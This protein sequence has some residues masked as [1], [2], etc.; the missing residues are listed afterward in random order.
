MSKIRVVV[1]DSNVPGQLALRD[2]AAPTPTPDAALVR[3]AA[4][5]LNRGEVRRST[6][7][8]AGW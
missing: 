4:I 8:E 7:A 3:V 2:V 5:S 6:T 1:V